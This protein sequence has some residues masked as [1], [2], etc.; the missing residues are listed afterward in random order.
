MRQTKF[1]HLC[2]WPNK[3]KKGVEPDFKLFLGKNSCILIF[4]SLSI[5]FEW[6]LLSC[7]DL[8]KF[9]EPVRNLD[10][11]NFVWLWVALNLSFF[12]FGDCGIVPFFITGIVVS[13]S[14]CEKEHDHQWCGGV[15]RKLILWLVF[16]FFFLLVRKLKIPLFFGTISCTFS[17]Q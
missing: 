12:S 6:V 17:P 3:C 15:Q 7:S 9:W 13:A 2:F 4:S 14:C 8:L 11:F 1:G 5:Q 16:G 10:C